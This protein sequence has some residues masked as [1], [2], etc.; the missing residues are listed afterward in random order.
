MGNASSV[1]QVPSASALPLASSQGPGA[2]PKE[3]FAAGNLAVT[4]SN[5]GGAAVGDIV[6]IVSAGVLAKAQADTSAHAAGQVG[7]WNGTTVVPLVGFRV[8]NCVAAPTVGLPLYVS[9]TIAGKGSHIVPTIGANPV[10]TV[11]SDAS[12]GAAYA[13]IVHCPYQPIAG[14]VSLRDQLDAETMSLLGGASSEWRTSMFDDFD[15]PGSEADTPT[16]N[17]PTW[18]NHSAATGIWKDSPCS[19]ATLA[20]GGGW[21]I[22]AN[23]FLPVGIANILGYQ[24][25]MSIRASQG[26]TGTGGLVFFSQAP[27]GYPILSLLGSGSGSWTMKYGISAGQQNT[28][29]LGANDGASLYEMSVAS[30]GDGTL[31]W[32]FNNGAWSTPINDA[33]TVA[34]ANRGN[35]SLGTFNYI[36]MMAAVTTDL[37]YDWFYYRQRRLS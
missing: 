16:H 2:M 32:R 7:L 34:M 10:G 37:T 1:Q 29:T 24:W 20:T 22:L 26:A 18:G 35:I 27:S 31:L 8:V 21:S 11:V 30:P 9:A 15:M 19:C 12:V 14:S 4:I 33:S 28:I 3:D 25:R 6:R 17:K 13:A 5:S 23:S 36:Y